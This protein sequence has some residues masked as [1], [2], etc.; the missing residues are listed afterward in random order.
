MVFHMK[1]V[2][3]QFNYPTLSKY[4][5]LKDLMLSVYNLVKGYLSSHMYV[6]VCH[7]YSTCMDSPV[8][9]ASAIPFWSAYLYPCVFEMPK[10][11]GDNAT[12]TVN[13]P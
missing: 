2:F 4:S 13:M 3:Y 11:Q 5:G 9:S 10:Y 8:V 12:C 6:N 7:V 1:R